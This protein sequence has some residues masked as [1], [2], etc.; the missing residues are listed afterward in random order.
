MVLVSKNSLDFKHKKSNKSIPEK[1]LE[2]DTK[3]E[4]SLEK[5]KIKIPMKS[6]IKKSN[7]DS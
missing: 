7:K 4:K 5:E 2:P 1:Y 3:S 6:S